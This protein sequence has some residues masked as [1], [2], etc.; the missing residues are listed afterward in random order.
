MN[1]ND[2]EKKLSPITSKLLKKQGYICFID[3]FIALGYLDKKEVE[4][5]RMK[6]I[7]YLEKCI[8]VNLGRIGFIIKTV[9]SNCIKGKLKESYTTYNSWGKGR[10]VPL[11]FSKS[12]QASIEK[13]YATHFI[14]KKF[15]KEVV[16]QQ[17]PKADKSTV[18]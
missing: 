1:R 8:Q 3:V 4:L 12:G 9:R 14:Q 13:I 6:R 17:G 10:K 5:W 2:L 7:P 15:F 18:E 16:P 11:R